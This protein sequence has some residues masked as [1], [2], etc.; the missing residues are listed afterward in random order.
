MEDCQPPPPLNRNI[1]VHDVA[2]VGGGIIGLSVARDLLAADPGLRLIILEKER[3]LAT[4]QT[5]R[6]SGVIHTGIYYPPGSLKAKLCRE[7]RSQ[8]LGFCRDQGVPYR[9]CGKVLVASHRNE[10]DRLDQLHRRGADNGVEGLSKIG[11]AELRD[12]EPN[13]AGVAALLVP[14]AAIIDFASVARAIADDL[15]AKGAQVLLAAEVLEARSEARHTRLETEAGPIGARIVVNCAGLHADRIAAKLGSPPAVRIVP[16]RGEYKRLTPEA[17][18]LVSGLVY[19]IP[20]PALPFLGAHFTPTIHGDVTVGPNAVLAFAREGY[21]RSTIDLRELRQMVAW[22]GFRGMIRQNWR[23]G[24][25]EYV[26]SFHGKSFLR[27]LQRLVP[28]VEGGHLLPAAA[29]VRAQAVAPDGKL[30][31]DFHI[32]QSER[33]VHVVN[34]PSPAAT[35][36]LAIGRH[37]ADLVR[38]AAASLER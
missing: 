30:V 4:H 22:K 18:G 36:S 16:F 34:A 17:R 6:N 8:L 32:V 25:G 11:P 33:A 27:A 20:D 15:K 9:I 28:A 10:L 31:D 3:A 5:G 14:G 37:V 12:R 19:P 2:I 21:T 7:G 13:V 38:D 26:R 23:S 24:A 29:G 35:A 1:E